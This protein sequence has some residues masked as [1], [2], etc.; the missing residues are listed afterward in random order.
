MCA[1]WERHGDGGY[2]F[3]ADFSQHQG[4]KHGDPGACVLVHP[5]Q[6]VAAAATNQ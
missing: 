3:G 4:G 1:G 2:A 6:I 5:S